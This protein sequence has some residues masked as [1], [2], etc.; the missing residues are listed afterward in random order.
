MT[1]KLKDVVLLLNQLIQ[2]D[3][4]AIDAYRTAIA[5]RHAFVHRAQ[6]GVLLADHRRHVDELSLIVRNL[7]G[8]PASQ[9][10]LRPMLVRDKVDLSGVADEPALIEAMRSS[11]AK[12]ASLYETA[13]SQPGI[14]VDVMSV[15]ERNLADER[16][17]CG[18]IAAQLKAAPPSGWPAT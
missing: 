10:D 16:N 8:E 7:G 3:H 2:R 15:L 17:H 6:L 5:T 18:W 1:R 11:E 13:V 14:P 9:T 4:T 12:T